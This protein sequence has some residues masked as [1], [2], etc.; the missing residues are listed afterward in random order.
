MGNN[1]RIGTTRDN[2]TSATAGRDEGYSIAGRVFLS[3]LTLCCFLTL[4]W[5]ISTQ[6]IIQ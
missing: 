3:I 2:W 5:A 6:T 1:R 4:A